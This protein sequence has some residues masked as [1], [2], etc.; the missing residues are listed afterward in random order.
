MP[1]LASVSGRPGGHACG[2]TYTPMLTRGVYTPNSLA[3]QG[4]PRGLDF[5]RVS[6]IIQRVPKRWYGYGVGSTASREPREFQYRLQGVAW[7]V[8]R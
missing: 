1:A 3:R 8:L 5:H 6:F 4:W 2:Y 7:Q